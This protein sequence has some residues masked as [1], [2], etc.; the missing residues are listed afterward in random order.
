MAIVPNTARPTRQ[1]KPTISP[2]RFRIAEIRCSVRSIPARLSP[3]NS[4]IRSA[5]KAR[6]SR[7]TSRVVSRASRSWNRAS[8]SLPKSMTISTRSSYPFGP[9]ALPNA[10]ETSKGKTARRTS[11][12]S[13]EG[14]FVRRPDRVPPAARRPFSHGSAP[15]LTHSA[16]SGA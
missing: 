11:R 3:P 5:T 12:L 2:V 8:G 16:P 13:V 6:S 7:R 15:L 4:P 1:V 9:A 10:S 14:E